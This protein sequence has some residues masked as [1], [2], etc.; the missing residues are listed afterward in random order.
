GGIALWFANNRTFEQRAR[1]KTPRPLEHNLITA[2]SVD[3]SDAHIDRR[4]GVASSREKKVA[5]V[6]NDVEITAE[7]EAEMAK[8]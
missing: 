6:K 3:K 5:R 7:H 2:A 8:Q 4:K 1:D